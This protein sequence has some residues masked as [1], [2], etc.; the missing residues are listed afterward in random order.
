MNTCEFTLIYTDFSVYELSAKKLLEEKNENKEKLFG[1][2]REAIG[3]LTEIEH[4]K[5]VMFVIQ[6]L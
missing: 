3:C 1:L 4:E 2:L 6:R 5:L